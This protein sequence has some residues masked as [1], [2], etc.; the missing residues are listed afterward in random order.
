MKAILFSI[1][2]F[3][4]CF[5]KAQEP[6]FLLSKLK[7]AQSDTQKINTLNA[8]TK[9]YIDNNLDS[10]ILFNKKSIFIFAAKFNGI[11]AA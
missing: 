2:I 6:T 10:A 9:I 1:L 3:I 5:C 4:T 7:K 11:A 8:L